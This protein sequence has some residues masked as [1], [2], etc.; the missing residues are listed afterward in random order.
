MPDIAASLRH[1]LDTLL[2]CLLSPGSQF[3]LMSLAS[4]LAIAVG[5]LAW[6][7]HKRG[8]PVRLRVILRALFPAARLRLPTVTADFGM[9]LFNLFAFGAAFGW[10][11]L[12]FDFHSGWVLASLNGLFGAQSPTALP[13]WATRSLITLALFLAYEFG[14]W[15]DHYLSHRVP[16]LWEF[17]KV[18]HTAE[19]LTPA[20]VWRVHPVDTVVFYNIL[21]LAMGVTYGTVSFVFGKPVGAYLIGG[22]NLLLVVFI[23]AY[24]HLQ[25][26]HMWIVFRGLAGRIFLSP[27][28]HQIHHSMNPAHFNRNL[29]SC[30]AVWDWVFGTLHIP[31][32]EREKLSFGVAPEAAP[33]AWKP[34]SVTGVLLTPFA[35]GWKHLLHGLRWLENAPAE[36]TPPAKESS[37]AP[38]R[39]EPGPAE[40]GLA[41]Q[42]PR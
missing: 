36:D 9:L 4:A 10:A 39:P 40:A 20:T 15:F 21:A 12:S 22:N 26:S 33:E 19:V 11:V 37:A 42:T 8:K 13:D 16:F 41:G 17:H 35:Q 30:L 24:V 6:K 1:L 28:H 25:H 5:F 7:R 32:R 18:H 34:H 27:A 3:S 2:D 31:S 23:Y 14:Y 38:G 29:G